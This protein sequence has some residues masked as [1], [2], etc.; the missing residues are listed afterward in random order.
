MNTNTNTN[1]DFKNIKT[2][3][4]FII[5]ITTG[6]GVKV[7]P[8]QFED[9]AKPE[10]RHYVNFYLPGLVTSASL[11]KKINT[12]TDIINATLDFTGLEFSPESF[13]SLINWIMLNQKNTNDWMISIYPKFDQKTGKYSLGL[14]LAI[15][16]LEK[17]GKKMPAQKVAITLVTVETKPC[18]ITEVPAAKQN[19]LASL[20]KGFCIK[21]NLPVP[22]KTQQAAA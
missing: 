3:G 22:T 1:T 9:R 10:A 5:G 6:Y 11:I 17:K 4:G 12:I 14:R 20:F 19:A 2:G 15:T 21:H 16:R 13:N 18:L 8:E 7:N